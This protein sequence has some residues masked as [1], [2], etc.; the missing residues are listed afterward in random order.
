MDDNAPRTRPIDPKRALDDLFPARF[1]KPTLL[2]RW[3]LTQL[4][5]T[6]VRI[7]EEEVKPKPTDP[8]EWKPVLYFQK[9]NG[10]NGEIFPQGYLLSAKIDKDS[11]KTATGA[12][13]L[14]ELTGKR[15]VIKLDQYRGRSVLR[16]DPQPPA[17]DPKPASETE[18]QPKP[19]S[20]PLYGSPPPAGSQP[21]AQR[22]QTP[23]PPPPPDE[24]DF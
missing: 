12:Q 24:E 14:G 3:N 15:I 18:S 17:D 4:T 7:Q 9:K 8:P 6:I 23:P 20:M 11:L 21:P 5:A 10:K 19:A 2:L 22:R 16:I 13:T 1:M